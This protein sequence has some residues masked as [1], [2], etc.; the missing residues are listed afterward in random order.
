M[1]KP[2]IKPLRLVL[3]FLTVGLFA[4]YVPHPQLGPPLPQELIE[5]L[6]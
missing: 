6:R 5:N 1:K 4:A 2:A 3:L